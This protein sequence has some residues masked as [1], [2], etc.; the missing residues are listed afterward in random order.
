MRKNN[1]I[2]VKWYELLSEEKKIQFKEKL[3]QFKQHKS[4]S[5]MNKFFKYEEED[6]QS[7]PIQEIGFYARELNIPF[8]I[9]KFEITINEK[10]EV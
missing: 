10:S 8:K 6:L 5:Y 1:G 3:R 9:E 2:L 4:W 7:L